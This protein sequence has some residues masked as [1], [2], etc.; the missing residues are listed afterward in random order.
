MELSEAVRAFLRSCTL[1]KNLSVLTTRAYNTDLRQFSDLAVSKNVTLVEEI[2]TDL[3]QHHVEDLKMLQRRDSSIRR[4]LAVVRAFLKF[5]E[6]RNIIEQN[7]FAKLKMRFKQEK[8]LP[9][10]LTRIEI[11][12]LLAAARTQARRVGGL[13]LERIRLLRDYAFLEF[14]FYTGARVGEVLK[15]DIGDCDLKA[16]IA[17]IKGK[18]RRERVAYIGCAPVISALKT[19][20]RERSSID[21]PD[22]ALFLNRNGRRLSVYSAERI[23]RTY[24]EAAGTHSRVTPHV[25]R[26]SMATMMLENGADIRSIQEILGHASISTTEIYT[27]VSTERKRQVMTE[28]HPRHSLFGKAG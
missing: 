16:G 8:R 4:K 5:L 21:T 26:H 3:L 18:G 1:D 20:M 25:F 23:V 10:V 14:L 15:L 22:A 11:T 28:F 7:P 24:A 6:T 2:T 27:H 19:Y 9:N 12:K 17:K 13:H